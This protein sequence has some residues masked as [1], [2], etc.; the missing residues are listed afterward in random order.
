MLRHAGRPGRSADARARARA[1]RGTADSLLLALLRAGKAAGK[2]AREGQ[3]CS[4]QRESAA[5]HAV[6]ERLAEQ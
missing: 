2:E 6:A 3:M 4:W 1:S 5:L